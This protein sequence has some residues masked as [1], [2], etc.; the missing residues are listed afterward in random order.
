VQTFIRGLPSDLLTPW[1][2]RLEMR[3][4]RVL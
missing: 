4:M 1:G 2:Y 3:A